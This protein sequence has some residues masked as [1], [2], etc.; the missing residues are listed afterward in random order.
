MLLHI[1]FYNI[2]P[3][4]IFFFYFIF[5]HLLYIS[6]EFFYFEIFKIINW[7]IL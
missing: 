7:Y 4:F 5:L 2:L 3:F 6:I 1:F